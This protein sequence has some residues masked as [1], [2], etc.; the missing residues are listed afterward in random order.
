M[1][2]HAF[3]LQYISIL[4]YHQLLTTSSYR[5]LLL[6]SIVTII[7]MLLVAFSLF[8][9][10]YFFKEPGKDFIIDGGIIVQR[11]ATSGSQSCVNITIID[12][13]VLEGDHSFTVFSSTASSWLMIVI[14]DNEGRV[15]TTCCNACNIHTSSTP[16]V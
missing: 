8:L 2:T 5:Q 15:D 6:I 7:I 14:E 11:G 12:D 1:A 3:F 13:E 4:I 10:L 9:I 16:P